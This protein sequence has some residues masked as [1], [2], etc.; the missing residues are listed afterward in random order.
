MNTYTIEL[1]TRDGKPFSFECPDEQNLLAAAALANIVL[2]A[3]CG[4]GNCGTCYAEVSH[5]DFTLGKHNA[6]A[7]SQDQ[8]EAGGTLLCCTFPKSAMRLTVPFNHDRIMLSAIPIRTARITT[9]ESV[10][11]NT[12]RLELQLLADEDGSVAANFEPGQFMELEVP[13]LSIK[14]AYSLANT[15]NW[16]G[17]LEFL[18]RLQ[19]GGLFSGWLREQAAV[20]Q[21]L[22][23]H[24]PKGAFGLNESGLRPRWFLAGGTGLA[25]MLSML[26]RMAE[27]QE[28]HPAK[29][30]FGANR[31]ADLFCLSELTALQTELPQL[32][33]VYCVW[34]AE[35]D[36]QGFT[37]TPVDALAQD[38]ACAAQLPDIYLCG[39]PGLID[40]AVAAAK[41]HGVPDTQ[42]FSERF[43]PS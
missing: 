6:N 37:G 15:P 23:V 38:L 19:A 12:L 33:V 5:G 14:R 10:G 7:L 40:A 13:G 8:A 17:R 36:W 18:I 16:D 35:P 26:R 21:T 25:P 34:Q 27:F 41:S 42:V 20:G 28:P 2:P 39:P 24:G 11:E 3:Q 1:T 22:L 32:Q 30:Y 31:I 4:Q 29:L 43:L 9:L